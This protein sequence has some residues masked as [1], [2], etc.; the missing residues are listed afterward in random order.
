[1]LSAP[2]PL[3]VSAIDG[4]PVDVGAR[5]VVTAAPAFVNLGQP[6]PGRRIEIVGWAGPWLLDVR[7]WD[8][9]TMRRRARFQVALA[10]GTAL[11]L[12]CDNGRWSIEA[13]YD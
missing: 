10:D 7:W 1:V 8:R 4:T 2:W 3:E 12:A 13:V 5:G 6:S 11:L 9:L